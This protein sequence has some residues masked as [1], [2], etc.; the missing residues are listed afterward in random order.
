MGLAQRKI[1]TSHRPGK[2]TTYPIRFEALYT[3][4]SCVYVCVCVCVRASVCGRMVVADVCAVCLC[5]SLACVVASVFL[6]APTLLLY[7]LALL[8]LLCF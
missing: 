5:V 8:V 6:C 3:G 7:S 2:S 1:G 4:E